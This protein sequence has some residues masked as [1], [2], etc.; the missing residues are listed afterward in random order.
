MLMNPNDKRVVIGRDVV[1]DELATCKWE[2]S[3]PAGVLF[4][5]EEEEVLATTVA[6]ENPDPHHQRRSQRQR[7][8]STRLV[9]L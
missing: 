6:P 5:F 3:E 2:K 9:R 8:P 4:Q 1:V 7:F